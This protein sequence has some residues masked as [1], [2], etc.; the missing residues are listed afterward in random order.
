M[1]TNPGTV[2]RSLLM[3]VLASSALAVT[4]CQSTKDAYANVFLSG[5]VLTYEQYLSID[6]NADPPISAE[7]VIERLGDPREVRDVDG[8]KR[9]VSFWAYSFTGDLKRAEFHF[10]RMGKLMKKELW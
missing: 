10:D 4:G 6:Q 9:M 7:T 3:L 1:R 2:A 5:T 8:V